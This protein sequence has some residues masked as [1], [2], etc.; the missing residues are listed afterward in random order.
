MDIL[1]LVRTVFQI[2]NNH[3]WASDF[4]FTRDNISTRDIASSVQKASG[5]IAS[6]KIFKNSKSESPS[7]SEQFALIPV[8]SNGKI[9]TGILVKKGHSA[10]SSSSAPRSSN[11]GTLK[12]RVAFNNN[13]GI[14]LAVFTPNGSGIVQV[15]YVS[16]HVQNGV[17]VAFLEFKDD[18]LKNS[19]F[20]SKISAPLIINSL[21]KC[22]YYHE[23]RKIC[24][25]CS[26]EVSKRCRC[27]F[28]TFNPKHPL[29]FASFA[30]NLVL[31]GGQFHVRKILWYRSK[32][33]LMSNTSS[34]GYICSI[35]ISVDGKK[36]SS[37]CNSA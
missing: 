22:E 28:N 8:F 32:E 11:T 26:R 2:P 4:L 33:T 9:T 5:V 37:V 34:N 18:M 30:P 10:G 24:L 36:V 27:T 20:G 29:D 25:I 16:H 6:L 3:S 13:L 23:E 1:K 21:Q 7:Y 14:L 17:K 31:L 12:A 15:L 19:V 35:Q